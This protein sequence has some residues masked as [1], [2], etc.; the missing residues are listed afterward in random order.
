MN[1]TVA[2]LKI[3]NSK[4]VNQLTPNKFKSRR[5]S[6]PKTSYRQYRRNSSTPH[7]SYTLPIL[8]TSESCEE[9][10]DN[11]EFSREKQ[12][13]NRSQNQTL[14]EPVE[15]SKENMYSLSWNDKCEMLDLNLEN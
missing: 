3:A 7:K 12:A 13:E 8:K 2:F 1:S 5:C 10:Y 9:D 11:L 14:I 6:K 4:N 15:S